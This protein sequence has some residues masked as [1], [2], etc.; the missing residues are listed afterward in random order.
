MSDLTHLTNFS[1]NKKAL[2]VYIML[3]NLPSGRRNSPI[4]MAVL[5][6]AFML[7]PL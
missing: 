5:L 2:P 4:S 6:L 1:D 7:T 3:G